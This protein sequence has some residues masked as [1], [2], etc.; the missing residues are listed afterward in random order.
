MMFH[1]Y[2]GNG[3]NHPYTNPVT[4]RHGYDSHNNRPYDPQGSMTAFAAGNTIST[5]SSYYGGGG[6]SGGGGGGGLE[7]RNCGS[8]KKPANDNGTKKN[9][10]GPSNGNGRP[11]NGKGDHQHEVPSDIPA[12]DKKPVYANGQEQTPT[13]NQDAGYPN[14]NGN[15]DYLGDQPAA[16]EVPKGDNLPS[17]SPNIP[18][19]P[20]GAN[21]GNTTSGSSSIPVFE[22]LSG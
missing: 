12:T 14:G 1:G 9:G 16:E 18:A 8:A 17:P 3:G 21:K 11:T 7:C 13:W 10:N 19:D 5:G 2:F 20:E 22:F 15:G 6:N 4:S